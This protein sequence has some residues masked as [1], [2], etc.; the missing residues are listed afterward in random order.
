M[1]R[2]VLGV[3]ALFHDSA[4]AL[5][6]DGEIV[7]CAQEERF[8]RVKHDRSLPMRAVRWCLDHEGIGIGDLEG[9][10]FYEKPLRKFE[11]IV[12]TA[13]ATFPRSW[14]AFNRSMHGWLGDR[15]WLKNQLVKTFGLRPERLFFSEHHLS[16]AASAYYCSPFDHAAVLTIDGV[17]EHCSTA[18][19]RGVG[20]DLQPV[21]EIR[22]PHSLGLFYSAF[23]AYLGFAVNN[24]EYKVMGMAPYG[25]PRFEPELSELLQ[26][27]EGGF[28]LDLSYFTFHWHPE[29]AYSDKLVQLLGPPR[30]P[31]TP[32]TP[33]TGDDQRF[34]DVAA[35]V[36][37]VTEGAVLRL[38]E[39]ARQTVDSPNLCLAGGVA[40]NSVANERLGRDGPFER[41]FVQ[42]AAGDAGGALGAA[43]WAWHRVLGGE[44]AGRLAGPALG[45]RWE[46]SRVDTILG[47]LGFDY[48][49]AGDAAPDQAADDIA[50]G[51]VI[52]W[53]EGGFEWG[54]R[55]L[56]HRSILA[57][58]AEEGM[59][60]TVNAR[61]KFREAFR[62][63]APAVTAEAASAW[64]DVPPA[65]ELLAPWM[66]TTARSLQPDK[67]AATTHVDGSSRVQVVERDRTPAFHRIVEGVGERTG[68]PVV[69]NTSFNLKGE[70]IVSSPVDAV[71]TLLRSELDV[72]YVEGF[73]M[74]RP[75]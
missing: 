22:Y 23:T 17:G 75:R 46:R 58:A 13:V 9:L 34:A 27:S 61:I 37:K 60:D 8:S 52:G 29:Q 31:G 42:P 16:H 36:Q 41:L 54:P 43:L 20:N 11:R 15:L 10:V 70:P 6:R 74:D 66:L 69:L 19:W 21:A 50:A 62:P 30:F 67:T 73:R 59:R 32:F 26:W 48:S 25:E 44:R 72:L 33:G 71:A 65:A 24:G 7:C 4:A 39:H 2:Y 35:S 3:S 40:L 28:S 12:A 53:V 56:G 51:K 63:F 49:D 45:R 38:A 68:T 5:L 57:N 18:L 64:F 1:P 55:A 14:R 47:D